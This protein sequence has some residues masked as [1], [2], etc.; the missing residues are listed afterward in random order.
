MDIYGGMHSS[1]VKQIA[2]SRGFCNYHGS[3]S[4]CH[5]VVTCAPAYCE[6]W[7]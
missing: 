6:A 2:R 1:N 3:L 4:T 7:Q 5:A